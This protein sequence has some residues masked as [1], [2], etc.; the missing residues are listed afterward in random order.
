MGYIGRRYVTP[1]QYPFRDVPEPKTGAS[2]VLG[3]LHFSEDVLLKTVSGP[4]NG[5]DS[6]PRVTPV[7]TPVHT[8]VS[9]LTFS[10]STCVRPDFPAHIR[11]VLLPAFLVPCPAF[12]P[13]LFLPDRSLKGIPKHLRLLERTSSLLEYLPLFRRPGCPLRLIFWTSLNLQWILR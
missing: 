10:Q 2:T 9:F 12:S 1:G 6:V 3:H 5:P 8:K 7:P 4:T 11:N 13:G